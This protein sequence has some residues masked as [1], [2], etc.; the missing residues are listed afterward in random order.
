MC[1]ALT[2]DHSVMPAA[3]LQINASCK[4]DDG[5]T[6]GRDLQGRRRVQANFED[7]EAEAP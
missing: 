5:P 1:F 2:D 4:P 7:V 6:V 3:L